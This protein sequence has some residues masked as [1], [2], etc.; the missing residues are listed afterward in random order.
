MDL[1]TTGYF[2]Q[3]N[4]V[5]EFNVE[6]TTKLVRVYMFLR[7]IGGTNIQLKI[8]FKIDKDINCF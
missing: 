8:S 7:Y 4:R 3:N 6:Y 2:K 5:K 1:M